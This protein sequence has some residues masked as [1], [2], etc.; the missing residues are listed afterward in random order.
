MTA[1]VV[2]VLLC[3]FLNACG[4]KVSGHTYRNNGGVVQAEF[5]S[6]CKAYVTAGPQHRNCTYSEFGKTVS[7][8]CDGTATSLT[9]QEDGA[10]AGPPGGL[11]ARLTPVKN[12]Q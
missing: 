7:L 1:F 2:I 9:V 10:L 6:G 5:K 11:M 8:I 4:S 3:P 12:Q